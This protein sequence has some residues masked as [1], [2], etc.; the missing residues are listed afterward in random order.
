MVTIR[1]KENS[2]QAKLLVEMLKTFD[3]VEF[4][5][6]LNRPTSINK[7]SKLMQDIETGLKQL[8]QKKEGKLK[9]KKLVLDG[10]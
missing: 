5:D 1:V 6:G 4:I 10:K 9:F 7:N 2:K 8:K 3:F